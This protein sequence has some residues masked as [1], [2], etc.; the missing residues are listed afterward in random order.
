MK[1]ILKTGMLLLASMLCINTLHAQKKNQRSVLWEVSGNGL[2]K[3][4]YLFG[5]IHMI[6]NE[7]YVQFNKFDSVY[8]LVNTVA[9]EMDVTSPAVQVQM[10]QGLMATDGKKIS[11]YFTEEEYARLDSFV[12]AKANGMSVKMF[13]PFHPAILISLMANMAIPCDSVRSYDME[14][15]NKTKSDKKELVDLEDVSVQLNV[16]KSMPIDETITSIKEMLSSE[17]SNKTSKLMDKLVAAYKAENL[18]QLSR[19]VNASTTKSEEAAKTLLEDR[20][21]AWIPKIET[22]MK[23]GPSL[24]TFGAAHYTGD[25]GVIQLLKDK[26]YKVVPIMK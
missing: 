5:T 23:K 18:K 25:L 21:K 16:L 3:P 22:L 17:A 15:I 11:E 20:N 9:V 24:I 13:E 12:Q 4:S 10:A 2:E 14:I 6:C 8:K 7:N 19:L 26:G 1:Y